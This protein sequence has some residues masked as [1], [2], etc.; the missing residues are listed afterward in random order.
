M[1]DNSASPLISI[2]TPSFNQGKYLEQTI[3]SVLGQNYPNLEYIIIDGGS[4]DNSLDV[5]QKYDD[6]ISYWESGKDTGQSNAINRGFSIATGQILGWLNSDDFYLPGTL[7]YIAALFCSGNDCRKQIVF[8]NCLHL[9]EEDGTAFGSNVVSNHLAFSLNLFDY[10][11]QPSSFW[12][13]SVFEDIGY[14]DENMIYAFDWEWFLRAE[15]IGIDFLAVERF[16]SVYRMHSSHKTSSGG[17]DRIKEI[18]DVYSNFASPKI[19]DIFMKYKNDKK[20]AVFKNLFSAP[21]LKK[22]FNTDEWL[23]RLFFRNIKLSEFSQ[24]TK[25]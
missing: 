5:L 16:L 17:L 8:G 19:A 22:V 2:V 4:D 20:V 23:Q 10:I 18:A 3:Q 11:I 15:R 21:L 9:V 1:I 13:K 12:S 14:L 25:M 7:E 24:I 6:S